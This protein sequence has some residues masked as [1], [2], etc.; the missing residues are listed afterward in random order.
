MAL[1]CKKCGFCTIIQSQSFLIHEIFENFL[2]SRFL[3]FIVDDTIALYLDHLIILGREEA[4][5]LREY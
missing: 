3:K 4:E 5:R 1:S 2:Q